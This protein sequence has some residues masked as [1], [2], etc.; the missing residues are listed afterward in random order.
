[1]HEQEKPASGVRAALLDLHGCQPGHALSIGGINAQH[2]AQEHGTPCY[3]YDAELLRSRFQ[4]VQHSLG[5]EILY[6]LKANP[7]L[8][9]STVLREA[10]AG[11][12][13]ASAGELL[14]AEKAG[15]GPASVQFAGPGKS[16]DELALALEQ[17]IHSIN[18][19]SLS[20]YESLAALAKQRKQ[21]PGVAIRVNPRESVGGSRMRMS[22]GSRKFGVDEDAVAQLVSHIHDQGLVDLHGL[23]CYMGTQ[24]FDAQAWLDS[25]TWLLG[26]AKEIE[27]KTSVPL[28]SLDFGGGFAV[29]CYEGDLEFDL[30]LAGQGMRTLLTGEDRRAFV[31]PG[32]YLVAPS[33]VFLTRV[34]HIKE[35]QGKR[36][37]ILDGGMHQH[38]A[39]AGLGS[40]LRRPYPIVAARDPHAEDTQ[41]QSLCG[42]LCTPA[43][44]F[45]SDL[46]LPRL[47][48]G[49]LV[50]ILASGAYGLTYSNLKFLSHPAPAEIL[51]DQGRSSVIRERGKPIDALAGQLLPPS[52]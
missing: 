41:A 48:Q 22:G 29:P 21:R 10:G 34:L 32:R 44:D 16:V 6:A 40:V 46:E 30:E 39:A 45:V 49:D 27:A 18:L 31:E 52:T 50:A 19:E 12:E 42:P 11:A 23:H 20:E 17:G 5:I 43:D 28:P 14:I 33:G 47:E 3:V 15:F 4:L 25:A 37:A 2:L 8:A 38:A 24:C 9:V 35:S 1:M 13:V 7:S 51:V 36:Y 26:F